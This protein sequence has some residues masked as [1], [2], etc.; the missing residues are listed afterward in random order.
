MRQRSRR[1]IAGSAVAALAVTGLSLATSAGASRPPT[2]D[3][4]TNH[5]TVHGGARTGAGTGVRADAGS[6][7]AWF[8]N[9]DPIQRFPQ[10]P[11]PPANV[12]APALLPR[13]TTPT[14]PEPHEHRPNVLLITT[15]DA[16]ITDMKYMPHVQHLITDK[17]VRFANSYAPTPICVPARASLLTG[18]YAHN[19]GAFTISGNGG[20]FPSFR[21]SNTLPV[22]LQRDGYDT[23][24]AGKYLN[25]YGEDGHQ[26]YQPPGWTDWEATGRGTYDFFNQTVDQNGHLWKVHRYTTYTMQDIANRMMASPRRQTRPWFLWL[27]Y[28]APHFGGPEY[29]GD[30][31]KATV[32]APRDVN[33]FPHLRLPK[34]PDMFEKNLSDKPP[35]SPSRQHQRRHLMRW[36]N[37]RRVQALQAV[38][39]AVASHVK[40]LRRTGQLKNTI[41]IFTSD[42]GYSVGEHNIF[43]KLWFYREIVRIP[44][45]MRG[46]GVPRHKVVQTP[47][48]NPDIEATILGATG[49]RSLRPLDGV[50]MLPWLWAPPQNR[51][52]PTEGWAVQN[53]S[54]RLYTGVLAGPW[55]YA[56]FHRGNVRAPVE[57]EAYD[58]QNDPYELDSIIRRGVDP[59]QLAQLRALDRAYRNCAGNTCPKAFY[60]ASAPP[61]QPEPVSPVPPSQR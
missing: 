7:A 28:V 16:A 60:P 35:H 36:L 44:V 53:G 22:A 19:H 59:V 17:G 1:T 33:D 50:N 27:N 12:I 49:A 11:H 61:A 54:N 5:S 20:G 48:T 24:F 9:P 29:D 43:G 37:R 4:G 26:T 39:R 57:Q 23:L 45:V 13:T 14:P 40:V 55:M 32:P 25:G 58:H 18:Q 8:P 6:G 38:D 52:I 10:R 15:D 31:H 30:P 34:R 46:P 3:T 51:V 47:I 21:D 56:D 2:D 41:I 42:N